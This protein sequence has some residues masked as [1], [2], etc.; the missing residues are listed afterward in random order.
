MLC[1]KL[2]QRAREER[3][4]CNICC[5]SRGF[6]LTSHTDIQ[7]RLMFITDPHTT[8]LRI[9][10]NA[11]H[12]VCLAC[13]RTLLFGAACG[14]GRKP[15]PKCM[16]GYGRVRCVFNHSSRQYTELCNAVWPRGSLLALAPNEAARTRLVRLLDKHTVAPRQLPCTVCATPVQT[17]LA[18][19]P[20][21]CILACATCGH[22]G[23]ARCGRAEPLRDVFECL[24]CRKLADRANP[25][26]CNGFFRCTRKKRLLRNREL[27]VERV[28]AHLDTL[29]QAALPTC[30]GCGVTMQHGTMCSTLSCPN[31]CGYQVCAFCNWA[32][33]ADQDG[34]DMSH[35]DLEQGG[36]PGSNAIVLQ[37]CLAFPYMCV[38]GECRT[39]VAECTEPEHAEGRKA[40]QDFV[41]R[42]FVSAFLFSL[43][44]HLLFACM[45]HVKGRNNATHLLPSAAELGEWL[46]IH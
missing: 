11:A 36:C 10:D 42:K 21:A 12:V 17:P 39:D 33:H 35:W 23:C 3:K 43:P 4:V 15:R 19:S 40:L 22:S 45:M 5:E 34:I 8:L 29:L 30:P 41:Q 1:A 25:E 44:P 6:V 32:E 9:C 14:R 7:S 20:S 28:Q 18:H 38:D 37:H 13:M 46:M 31:G 27:S 16:D 26:A 24:R 2:S